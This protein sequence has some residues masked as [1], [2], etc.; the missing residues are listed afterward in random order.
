MCFVHRF[1]YMYDSQKKECASLIPSCLPNL[2]CLEKIYL[3][4]LKRSSCTKKH[5]RKKDFGFLE[6]PHHFLH[7]PFNGS[8]P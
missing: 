8:P 4:N 7:H 2:L 1:S 6:A 3:A 5:E